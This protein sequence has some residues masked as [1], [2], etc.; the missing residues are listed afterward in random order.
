MPATQFLWF[1]GD[2]AKRMRTMMKCL[3]EE[4]LQRMLSL[5]SRYEVSFTLTNCSTLGIA[6]NS[7]NIGAQIIQFLF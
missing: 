3:F 7:M 4:I 2:L 1:Y 6:I 5:F